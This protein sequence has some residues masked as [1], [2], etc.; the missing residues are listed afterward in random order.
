MASSRLGI[1]PKV[2]CN[3]PNKTLNRTAKA[4]LLF[5]PLRSGCPVS[6]ALEL[7]GGYRDD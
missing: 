2:H 7:I 4:S 5:P 3:A 1:L 6:L